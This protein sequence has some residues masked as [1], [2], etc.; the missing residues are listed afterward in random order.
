MLLSIEVGLPTLLIGVACAT[1]GALALVTFLKWREVR[2][3]STWHPAPG[4]IIASTVEQRSV[5]TDLQSGRTEIRNF[6]AITFE[7]QVAGKKLRGNRYSLGENVG[8]FAVA[9]TLARFPRGRPVTVFYDPGDPTRAVIERT[10]P[11][12]AL[13]F[14]IRLSIGLVVGAVALVMGFSGLF[15]II[16]PHVPRPELAAPAVFMAIVALVLA[17]MG[18]VLEQQARTARQ[19]PRAEGRIG[20][21]EVEEIR[22]RPST[23][24]MTSRWR[25]GYRSLVTYAFTVNGQRYVG[26]R[27]SFGA[28]WEATLPSLVSG[29]AD[30]YRQGNTVEVYYN[31]EN[32]ADCVL[33][34]RVGGVWLIWLTMAAS[35]L[36]AIAFAIGPIR[37]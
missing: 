3:A 29:L 18:V 10:M 14:M 36:A 21:S 1:A 17:R 28:R 23:D 33:E 27:I 9:E 7:Y 26:E 6:P 4:K 32:P 24:Q 13:Q 22:L 34:P 19:W 5:T 35:G 30:R 37:I 16:K 15:E 11:D 31:P 12:G 25:K 8:N 2:E 20:A